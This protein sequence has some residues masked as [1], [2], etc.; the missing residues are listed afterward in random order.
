MAPLPELADVPFF[1]KEDYQCGPAALA[2]VLAHNGVDVTPDRLASRLFVPERWPVWHYGTI[3]RQQTRVA[4]QHK[5]GRTPGFLSLC[6]WGH[7][8]Q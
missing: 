5:R 4:A 3:S 7:N 1:A 8:R 6:F 2:T